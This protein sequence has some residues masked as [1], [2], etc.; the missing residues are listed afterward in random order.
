VQLIDLAAVPNDDAALV[1]V[2]DEVLGHRLAEFV[3]TM[4]QSNEGT[5]TRKPNGGLSRG[6]A[7][8]DHGNPRRAAEL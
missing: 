3:A 2:A 8:A 5:A 6:V 1:E 4:Q 7:A